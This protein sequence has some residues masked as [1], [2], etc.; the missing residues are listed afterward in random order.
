MPEMV[1]A[2][3]DA[4]VVNNV[5]R[6]EYRVLSDAEKAQ[7]KQIKD[8]GRDFVE[9]CQAIG[10]SPEMAQAIINARQAVMWAVNHITR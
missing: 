3:S 7:M 6:H 1:N 10:E 9:A 5:V 4:R 8:M 2:A